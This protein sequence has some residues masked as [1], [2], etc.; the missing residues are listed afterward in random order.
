MGHPGRNGLRGLMGRGGYPSV[1]KGSSREKA[2]PE[3][4]GR[5]EASIQCLITLL[6]LASLS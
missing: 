3:A 2:D 5:G 1:A 6:H 4:L